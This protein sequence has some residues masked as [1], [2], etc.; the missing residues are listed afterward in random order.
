MLVVEDEVML[1]QAI[2]KKLELANIDVVSSVSG[3][4][5]LDYMGTL[6]QL[7]DGIW[8]DYYLKDMDG[9]EFMEQLKKNPAWANIPV[10]VVSNSASPEKINRM[11]ALG[12]KEY[13]VKSDYSL[14]SVIDT[15]TDII[16]KSRQGTAAST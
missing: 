9:L 1:A 11:M 13:L 15:L 7:P 4:Q 2:V 6:T 10:V 8:L 16:R 5:A 12:A 14:Q 3:K